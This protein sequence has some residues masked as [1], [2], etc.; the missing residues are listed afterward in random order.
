MSAM[1]DRNMATKSLFWPLSTYYETCV[2]FDKVINYF[3]N[4]SSYTNFKTL[5]NNYRYTS[6]QILTKNNP[7]FLYF[8]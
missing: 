4:K 7:Y 2:E 3:W 8:F 6:V 5:K 1:V